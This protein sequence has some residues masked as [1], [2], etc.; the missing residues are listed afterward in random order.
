MKSMKPAEAI[1]NFSVINDYNSIRE[2]YCSLHDIEPAAFDAQ[3]LEHTESVLKRTAE[4]YDVYEN[5]GLDGDEQTEINDLLYFINKIMSCIQEEQIQT[6]VDLAVRYCWKSIMSFARWRKADSVL[7]EII[8]NR[9]VGLPAEEIA[10]LELDILVYP[11][12]LERLS[13]A[14]AVKVLF[15][16]DSAEVYIAQAS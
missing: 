6:Y 3:V 10:K 1:S 13:I 2:R 8:V 12:V 7:R 4:L 9:V 5:R 16:D 15:K 14:D 11:M